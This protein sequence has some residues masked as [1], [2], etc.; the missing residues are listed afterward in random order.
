MRSKG[1]NYD[2]GFTPGGY[3]SREQFDPDVVGL[4][5]QIIAS[6]LKW[7]SARITGAEPGRL[8]VAGEKAAAAGLEVWFAPFS[9]EL[10]A[11]E[12]GPLFGLGWEP[13]LA[14]GALAQAYA[15]S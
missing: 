2:T 7:T 5:M 10:T 15:A 3:L 8:S 11:A 6:Q 12:L 4:E 9:C 13:K 14:F 1:I